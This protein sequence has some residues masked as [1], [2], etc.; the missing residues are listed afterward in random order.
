[1]KDVIANLDNDWQITGEEVNAYLRYRDAAL[2]VGPKGG[3]VL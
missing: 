3:E 1:M 2:N